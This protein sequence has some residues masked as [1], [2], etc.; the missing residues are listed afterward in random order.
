MDKEVAD[1]SMRLH[2]SLAVLACFAASANAAYPDE[3][4]RTIALIPVDG[5]LNEDQQRLLDAA[6]RAE[7]QV[8]GNRVLEEN[9][10]LTHVRGARSLG[11]GC[12]VEASPA[13]LTF[14]ADVA[15]LSAIYVGSAENHKIRLARYEFAQGEIRH[16]YFAE[17]DIPAPGA[18]YVKIA[19]TLLHALH[20][21]PTE[22]EHLQ[23][24]EAMEPIEAMAE[25]QALRP[26]SMPEPV[27]KVHAAGDAL[28]AE[29]NHEAMPGDDR[30]EINFATIGDAN[31]SLPIGL[32]GAALLA[33]GTT[34]W[35]FSQWVSRTPL[36]SPVSGS[37][38]VSERLQLID[39]T[40]SIGLV[41]VISG[42]VLSS[43]GGGL[44]LWPEATSE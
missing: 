36:T 7:L 25:T 21:E 12:Q 31:I 10:R 22:D 26:D 28:N 41:L 15:G 29:Q 27:E 34:S 4:K 16:R 37:K 8:T 19:Q 44:A 32:G 43:V 18:S 9:E 17:A 3:A 30:P 23:K 33:I 20:T 14:V 6:L 39:A 11:L 42:A 38:S 13:C 35:G 1:L 2:V 40:E 24:A 5:E